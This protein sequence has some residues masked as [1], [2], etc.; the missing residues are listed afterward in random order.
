MDVTGITFHA[1][2]CNNEIVALLGKINK[3]LYLLKIQS[4]YPGN[5][6]ESEIKQKDKVLYILN[7]ELLVPVHLLTRTAVMSAV[8]LFPFTSHMIF[9]TG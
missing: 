2:Q 5:S 4:N 7:T 8:G 3:I 1:F 6:P 9:R